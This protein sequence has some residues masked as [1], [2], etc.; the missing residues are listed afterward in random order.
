MLEVRGA[1]PALRKGMT[2]PIPI[3]AWPVVTVSAFIAFAAVTAAIARPA[4][5]AAPADHNPTSPLSCLD[6]AFVGAASLFMLVARLPILQISRDLQ[7]DEAQYGANALMAASGWLNW[8]TLDS[9]SSGPLN[10][11]IHAWP[12][13]FGIDITFT[14]IHL[15]GAVIACAMAACVYLGLRRMIGRPHALIFALPT[16][17]F[18]GATTYWDLV[19]TTSIYFPLTLAVFGAFAVVSI[20][21]RPNLPLAIAAGFALGMI[22]LAKP[23]V[24]LLGGYVGL[25]LLIAQMR[26]A[27]TFRDGALKALAIVLA[28]AVPLMLSVGSLAAAGHLDDFVTEVFAYSTAY[29]GRRWAPL[30]WFLAPPR[31]PLLAS[32][33]V[34]Y[35]ASI[36]GF[37]WW[38]RSRWRRSNGITWFAIGLILTGCLSIM[39]PGQA[40]HHYL[41][42]LVPT[43]PFAAAAIAH[44]TLARW[45]DWRTPTALRAS[46]AV[47][48]VALV[49]LPAAIWEAAR[50]PALRAQGA[51][52]A[53]G[54]RLHAPRVLSWLRP[55]KDD[56][57]IVFGYMPYLYVDAGMQSG[58]RETWSETVV[59]QRKRLDR[60]YYRTRFIAEMDERR[61]AIFID[62][63]APGSFLYRDPALMG[64]QTFPALAE[65]LARDYERIPSPPTKAAC[66][67]IY[68]RRDRAA[69]LQEALVEAA[70]ASASS[71]LETAVG[72]Y[73]PEHVVDRQI[74]ETCLDRWL[75]REGTP[76][77]LEV[78]LTRPERIARVELLNTRGEWRPADNKVLAYPTVYGNV[79]SYH[80]ARTVDVKLMR[81]ATVL[82]EKHV[83]VDGYPYWTAVGFDPA[84]EA[85]T[86]IRVEFPD[87]HGAG[88]GLNEVVAFR[89]GEAHAGDLAEPTAT[90]SPD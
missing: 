23:H 52:L 3:D 46:V 73:A 9:G 80:A 35:A 38:W 36:I 34:L 64:P 50:S 8:D 31:I 84:P 60:E 37:G 41:L 54:A 10:S 63:V 15:T 61:P 21:Q 16:T 27:A 1:E 71:H 76:A 74:F 83:R 42:I 13:L 66:M 69:R 85:A 22:P 68:L 87:W 53:N 81:G 56:R 57:L 75:A 19:H 11:M 30:Y 12:L 45:P 33:I 48:A 6:F 49:M 90:Q 70:A 86:A 32:M 62:A 78:T 67:Q 44:E 39:A 29:V 51:M 77:W 2:I 40:H 4:A 14:T 65:R 7:P 72:A 89:A 26:S 43:L 17:L 20:W 24:A 59:R 55:D 79:A 88:P 18:L 82:A 47:A 28:A 58:T 5:R 25:A